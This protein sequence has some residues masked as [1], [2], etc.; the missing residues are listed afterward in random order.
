MFMGADT[1]EGV[2][3]TGIGIVFGVL[4]SSSTTTQ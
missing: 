1:V 2:D 3:G 4:F